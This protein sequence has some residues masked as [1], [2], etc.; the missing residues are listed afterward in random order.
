MILNVEGSD[1]TATRVLRLL[2]LLQA[3][4]DWT[5]P[6]LAARQGVST[7]TVRSDVARLRSLGYLIDALPGVTG[8]YRL[9]GGGR[10]PPLLLDDDEAV[11]VAVGL[12]TATTAGV[13]GLEEASV[14][15][16]LKLEQI[17]PSRLRHRVRSLRAATVS[18]RGHTPH[19]DPELLSS[20][21]V[22]CRDR[23]SLHID[24]RSHDD[25]RSRR[26]IEPHRLVHAGGRWYVVAWDRSIADWR[27]LRA[28]RIQLR[29]PNGPR[30]QPR[31]L[32]GDGDVAGH[33]ARGVATATWRVR[34]RVTVHAATAVIR[35]RLPS[36]V[37]VEPL[38]E[39][40]CVIEVGSDDPMMLAG[41][42]ALLGA[43]FTVEQP[44]EL[45]DALRALSARLARAAGRR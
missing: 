27:T 26:L 17:M 20:L 10:L 41:Y 19:L 43:D 45:V 36:T 35:A 7:R 15:A 25:A 18:V 4:R 31:E 11:A 16:L 34:A 39:Q 40:T 5:G 14:G 28:D 42:L 37:P 8:G 1:G 38:D 6:E 29:T 44:A 24:Y 2:G 30:F 23:E 32:P 22:A 21:A 12:S 33:V 13:A 3:R 9:G